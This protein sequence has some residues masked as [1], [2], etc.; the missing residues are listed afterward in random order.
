[1]SLRNI[2]ITVW[3]IMFLSL[4]HYLRTTLQL[5][6]PIPFLNKWNSNAK[7]DLLRVN[8]P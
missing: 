2:C 6:K 5:H 3:T 1:M 8:F 4:G 7:Y